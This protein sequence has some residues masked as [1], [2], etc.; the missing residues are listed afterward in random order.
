MNI[1]LAPVLLGLIATP[2]LAE[3]TVYEASRLVTAEIDTTEV[4]G[5]AVVEDDG[6]FTP[7]KR[8]SFD[9]L[10]VPCDGGVS[11]TFSPAPAPCDP[12]MFAERVRWWTEG[13]TRYVFDDGADLS[14]PATRRSSSW[15]P[16]GA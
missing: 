9:L 15:T 16:P 3:T 10:V 2:L 11:V 8:L 13:G 6:P 4:V 1:L 5:S 12:I 7:I 14:Q